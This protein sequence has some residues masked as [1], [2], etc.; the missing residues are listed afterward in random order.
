MY[1]CNL[2][3]GLVTRKSYFATKFV[4]SKTSTHHQDGLGLQAVIFEF[5]GE[6]NC[7]LK[8]QHAPLTHHVTLTP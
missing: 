7:T 2:T 5:L 8:Q 3:G 6:E 4:T 1:K